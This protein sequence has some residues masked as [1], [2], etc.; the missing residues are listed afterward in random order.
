MYA[1]ARQIREIIIVFASHV[2]KN[3]LYF[4]LIKI[5]NSLTCNGPSDK[6]CTSCD[7]NSGLVLSEFSCVCAQGYYEATNGACYLCNETL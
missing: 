6:N 4:K 7:I 5:E 2:I 3:G 1:L